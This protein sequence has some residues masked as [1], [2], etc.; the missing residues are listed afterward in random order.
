MSHA[1]RT[2]PIKRNKKPDYT[3]CA[4]I[5]NQ[6][7]LQYEVWTNF[8]F[9]KCKSKYCCL[10]FYDRSWAAKSKNNMKIW[11]VSRSTRDRWNRR[12][13]R[14]LKAMGGQSRDGKKENYDGLRLNSLLSFGRW[15][16]RNLLTRHIFDRRHHST[17]RNKSKKWDFSSCCINTTTSFNG[18]ELIFCIKFQF[19]SGWSSVRLAM[20]VVDVVFVFF[21]P[22]RSALTAQAARET[23]DVNVV[24]LL[25]TTQWD[26]Q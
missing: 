3:D 9:E 10:L 6:K 24:S 26:E 25:S 20:G 7:S 17:L 23:Q 5:V 21:L 15:R 18:E 22:I 11:S 2:N 12:S 8:Y 4:H 1:N 13:K 19:T 14:H 16:K